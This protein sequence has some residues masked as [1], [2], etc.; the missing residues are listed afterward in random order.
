LT[1]WP[2]GIVAGSETPLTTNSELLVL[3]AETVTLAPLAVRLPCA[4]PLVPTTTLPTGSVAAA[5][6]VPTGFAPVPLNGIAR[7]VFVAFEVRVTLPLAEPADPGVNFTLKV[8]PCPAANVTGAVM[9]LRV[10]P[11]PLMATLEMTTEVPP[12]LVTVS[13][14]D[15]LLPTVTV[16][17][18]R[19]LGLGERS[20]A[21]NPVPDK[22]MV[23]V[24]LE[25]SETMVTVPAAAPVAL[26]AKATEK[27]VL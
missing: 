10:N 6:R 26:G 14:S 5:L 15:L 2:A 27:V 8:A 18:P 20:P 17:K 13:E 11:V 12:V 19:E 21:A 7:V 3:A 1:L 9:P 23:K 16:L 24:G 4:S 25:P 22:D